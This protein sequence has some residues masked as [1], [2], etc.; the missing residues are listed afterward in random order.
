MDILQYLPRFLSGLQI[1][2]YVTVVSVALGYV[3]GLLLAVVVSARN[4]WLKWPGLV[5]VELGRGT[6]ALVMLYIVYFGLPAINVLFDNVVAAIIALTITTAAYSSEM[7]RGGLQSVAKGQVEAAQ[8]L[9]LER[10]TVFGRVIVPQGLRSAIPSL[11]GLAIQM[12]QATS[13]AYSIA[14]PEL[15]SAAYQV[16]NAT[17]EYLKVFLIAGAI[18]AVISMPVTWLSVFVERRMNRNYS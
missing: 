6:P 1:S 5:L 3:I 17:F 12:F 9:G 18:Y 2:L 16:G 7:I 11:M 14:V 10:R 8:A 15:M 4:P 13:L